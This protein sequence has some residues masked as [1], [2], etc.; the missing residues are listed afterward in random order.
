M[1]RA[2]YYGIIL[3]SISTASAEFVPEKWSRETYDH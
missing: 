1:Q 2:W 3:R